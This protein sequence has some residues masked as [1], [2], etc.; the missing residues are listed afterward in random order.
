[1]KTFIMCLFVAKSWNIFYIKLKYNLIAINESNQDSIYNSLNS[2]NI[3][4]NYTKM[5]RF[6][7]K[8]LAYKSR[9]KHIHV[10]S[11][12]LFNI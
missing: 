3:R 4:S 5:V 7:Y 8:S 2:L 10:L 9:L 6:K 1:M 11:R 12:M